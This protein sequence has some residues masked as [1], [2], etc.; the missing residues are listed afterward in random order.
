[1]FKSAVV[2]RSRPYGSMLSRVRSRNS[3][4]SAQ[5]QSQRR[6]EGCRVAARRGHGRRPEVALQWPRHRRADAGA[7]DD[8]RADPKYRA[9]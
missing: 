3:L 8:R 6:R 5:T 9:W 1:M 7:S 2:G 4:R